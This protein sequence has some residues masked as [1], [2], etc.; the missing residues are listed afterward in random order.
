MDNKDKIIKQHINEI[1]KQKIIIEQLKNKLYNDE[2]I[3]KYYIN[4]FNLLSKL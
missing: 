2:N 4:K 3:K 1:Y